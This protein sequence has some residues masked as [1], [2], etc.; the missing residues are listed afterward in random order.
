MFLVAFPQVEGEVLHWWYVDDGKVISRGC[1]I[2]PLFSAGLSGTRDERGEILMIA[3]VPTSLVVLRRHEL[4][5]G[6]TEQQSASAAIV[7]ARGQS[8]EPGSL[9]WTAASEPGSSDIVSASIEISAMQ[10]GLSHLQRMGVD[11]DLALPV[12]C[13][14]DPIDDAIFQADFSFETVIRS[15]QWITWDQSGLRDYLVG[16]QEVRILTAD[17]VDAALV[18]ATANAYLNFRS[19]IFAKKQGFSLSDIQR[20]ILTFLVAVLIVISIAIPVVQL[21]KYHQAA[22]EADKKALVAANL[23]LDNATDLVVAEQQLGDKIISESLG[24][25]KFSIP[26]SALFSAIQQTPGVTIN[27]LSYDA[28]GTLGAELTALRNEE[29]NPALITLQSY[30]FVITATPRQD[31]TGA[32]KAD[33][34]VRLP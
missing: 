10:N 14:I 15:R 22:D 26:A 5:A 24:N 3:L 2:D 7:E 34:T 18:N 25:G 16:N 30:G 23:V 31:A 19:G 28:N 9:H 27:R 20:K 33:I 13:L 1:D 4:A 6:L 17:A 12:G 29:I 32:A 8:L 11:P 21:I